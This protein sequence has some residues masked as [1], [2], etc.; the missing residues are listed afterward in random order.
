MIRRHVLGLLACFILSGG[1]LWAVA[2]IHVDDDACPAVGS[3]TEFDPFC[4]IQMA[5]D[6]ALPG[7]TV[8]VAEG[9]YTTKHSHELP[10]EL[11]VFPNPANLIVFMRDQVHLVG[12]GAGKSILDAGGE[13]RVVMFNQVSAGTRFEGFT[14]TG[15]DL[16]RVGDGGGM[17][18]L[19]SSPRI[20]G[21]HI[22]GNRAFFG[23]GIEVLY[24]SSPIIEQNVF[25]RNVAGNKTSSIGLGAG[26]AIDSAI[27]SSPI[28]TENWIVGNYSFGVGG[29]MSFYDSHGFA[30]SNRIE[31]NIA[32]GHGGGVYSVPR[33]SA[34]NRTVTLRSNVISMNVSLEEE[35]TGARNGGGVFAGEGTTLIVN[36]ISHNRALFGDGGGV[37]ALGPQPVTISYNLIFSN[38]AVLGGGVF[39][40]PGFHNPSVTG[41]DTFANLPTDWEGISDPSGNQGNFSEEPM[42]VNVPDFV[43]AVEVDRF[44][45]LVLPL[46]EEPSR[47]FAIGD[48]VEYGNDGVQRVVTDILTAPG[49]PLIKLETDPIVTPQEAKEFPVVLRRW[50]ANTVLGENFGTSVL[51]PLV[52]ATNTNNAPATDAVG[53]VRRF[54]GD[55]AGQTQVDIGALENLAELEQLDITAGGLLVWEPFVTRPWHYHI[56][57]GLVT[58]LTDVNGDGIP[59]GADE[60]PG[61]ADDGY[62]DCLTP[63]VDLPGPDFLDTEDPLPGDIFFYL[64]SIADTGEGILGFDSVER[65]R[66]VLFPCD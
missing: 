53:H 47:Q 63:G 7:D 55:L 21:N 51:S 49:V 5:I 40:D 18:V 52:D 56:Y 14:V 31:G 65:I 4:D 45:A 8:S 22:V 58:S 6:S 34:G 35:N 57:R 13:D 39:V 42:L 15:G 46:D 17:M 43:A 62:G 3:G 30:D 10:P 44:Q 36:T 60:L 27:E 54:D 2:T 1:V 50:G 41:N 28:I 25:E 26:A 11:A 33:A 23:G 32:E 20:T 37:Y 38:S 19:F 64:A 16:D 61:T 12:A 9:L 24:Y 59:D 48:V 66:P 29:A